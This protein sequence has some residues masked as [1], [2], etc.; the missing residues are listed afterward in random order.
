MYRCLSL[1]TNRFLF[2]LG[3][4]AFSETRCPGE[5]WDGGT[6]ARGQHGF[7]PVRY[8]VPSGCNEP[9]GGGG[10][11]GSCSLRWETMLCEYDGDRGGGVDAAEDTET[12]QEGRDDS[13][14]GRFKFN[15]AVFRL[16]VFSDRS[17]GP[18][19]NPAD[20]ERHLR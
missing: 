14:G 12:V 16:S 4:I 11:S 2:G 9:I 20:S 15:L 10:N 18:S 1:L 8:H 13:G 19:T 5:S 6:A 7:L 3:P 17:A